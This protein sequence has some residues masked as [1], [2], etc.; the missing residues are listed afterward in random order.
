M[1]S[2]D[3]QF[4]CHGQVTQWR[5]I[6]HTSKPFRAIVWRPVYDATTT[7]VF[8]IVGINDIPAGAI[9]KPVTYN[10]PQSKHI[11]VKPGDMI[12]W[13][14][15]ASVLRYDL[16]GTHRV[17]WIGGNKYTGLEVNQP[18]NI[19]KNV[20]E[21]AYSIQAIVANSG[22]YIYVTIFLTNFALTQRK[23]D[24]S[25]PVSSTG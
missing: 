24:D 19:S 15:K 18:H 7:T 14:Y 8:E 16:G 2:P 9:N 23:C 20:E 5:Y 10:V 12:G 1:V 6:G 25:G 13:S 4:Y 22:N 11:T 3:Q 21:R 17:R